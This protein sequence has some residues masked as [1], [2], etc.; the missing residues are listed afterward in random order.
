MTLAAYARIA[1]CAGLGQGEAL[2]DAVATL[3]GDPVAV[4]DA[5]RAHHLVHLVRAAVPE[6]VLR[7]RLRPEQLQA[8]ASRRP[9]QR[10]APEQLLA[11]FEEVRD[12]LRP[13]GVPVLLLKGL[14]FADRL[15]G[16]LERRPQFDLDLLVRRRHR[17]R[18]L[19][20]LASR[21]FA[22][23]ARDLHS[24]T[25]ARDS[26]KIDLH[27]A[28]RWAPAYRLD[29]AVLWSGAVEREI[30]GVAFRTL[31]DE[32]TIVG[33][34]LAGFEDL[35]QGMAKLKSLLDLY[36]LARRIDIA[37]DWEAFF[38]RRAGE[39]LLAIS[40]NVIAL[41]V[42]LFE[43]R[44]ELPRLAAALATRRGLYTLADREQVYALVGAPRKDPASFAWFR[45]LYP[46]SVTLYL[47]WFWA[48]GLPANLRDLDLAR[49][50]GTVAV[51]LG[52]GGPSGG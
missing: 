49:L 4:A 52:R 48:A 42:D 18:A 47:L 3:P 26:L 19:R 31:S 33:L 34:V 9:I 28:L 15:Y 16:G 41:V 25:V 8:L 51:A 2:L 6:P 37:M 39:N 21:G 36:L 24:R 12:A 38:E 40:V 35:G 14:V 23:K 32:Y 10:V 1:K 43:A 22:P 44:A 29:E 30:R 27:H 20:T 7:A 17:R 11:A 45:Q 50:R 13:V 5:L 46:G